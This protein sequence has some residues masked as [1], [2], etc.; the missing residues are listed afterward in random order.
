[1][2]AYLYTWNPD[3]FAWV[4]FERSRVRLENR[5][6]VRL[7]WTC[8]NA[9]RIPAGRRF[10]LLRQGREPR[11]IVGSGRT[12]SKTFTHTW[13]GQRANFNDI[14]FDA[15]VPLRPDLILGLKELLK[16]DNRRGYW[17][18][19]SSGVKV[20]ARIEKVL[21][22]KWQ[23]VVERSNVRHVMEPAAEIR[24]LLEERV[25]AFAKVIL[26]PEQAAFR[27]ELRRRHGDQ[28]QI[29][30]CR[31]MAVVN[32]CH[33]LRA[34]EGGAEVAENG[35]LL[36]LDLHVLFDANLIGIHPKTLRVHVHSS[37]RGTEY[38]DMKGT[39]VRMKERPSAR[40]LAARWRAFN[41]QLAS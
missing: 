11:G 12:I 15:L 4:D 6:R 14:E 9:E 5:K 36:R 2:T 7:R 34:A 33:L 20:P 24:S 22:A 28:C 32:A 35:I 40:A 27:E 3:E 41:N 31:V 16:V 17:G 1:M 23:A 39:T 8:G 30:G 10:Y 18:V 25:R 29:S 19:R 38:Q 21:E 37:L 13:R 26:R